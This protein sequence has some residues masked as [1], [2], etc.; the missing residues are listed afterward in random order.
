MLLHT[1]E[2]KNYRSLEHVTLENLTSFNI[3]I[4][5]NDVGK[6]SVFL[7]LEDLNKVLRGTTVS[8]D[9]L[10]ARDHKRSWEVVLM[11]ALRDRDR[12][13]FVD[14]LI[15]GGFA[16]EHRTAL[17]SSPFLRYIQFSFK[18]F[19]SNPNLMHLQETKICAEDGKWATI[20]SILELNNAS[21]PRSKYIQLAAVSKAI[22]QRLDGQ[23]KSPLLAQLLNINHGAPIQETNIQYNQVITTSW[24]NDPATQWLYTQL[25]KYFSDAFFFSSFRHSESSLVAQQSDA[26][27]QNGSNLVQV[28]FTLLANQRRTFDKIN[29][30]VHDAIPDLGDLQTSLAGN[31]TKIDFSDSDNDYA[32]PL[33][34][35]GSGVEQ[36]LM[37]AVVLLT[38][39]TRYHTLFFEEPECHL[40]A[41]ARRFLIDQLYHED[42][43]V[44]IATHSSTFINLS[45]PHSLYRVTQDKGRTFIT[46]CDPESL[47]AVLEDIGVRNSDVLLSDAVLFV[48]GPGDKDVF[49]LLSEK[50]EMLLS[51]RNINV[52]P[53]G[54]GRYAERGAPIRSELLADISQKSPVPHLFVIDR[55]ER[56]E[57][58]TS[59]LERRLHGHIHVLRARELENYLLIP[60]AILHAL[61]AK[62]CSDAGILEKLAATHEE[63]IAQLIQNTANDLYGTVLLKRIRMHLGAPRE[64]LLPAQALITLVPQVHHSD[65]ASNISQEIKTY[66]D[67]HIASI[68]IAAIVAKEKQR[69]DEAWQDHAVRLQ[70]APGEEILA[71][72]FT[73]FGSTYRKSKDALLIAKAMKT[74]DISPE[75][76]ELIARVYGLVSR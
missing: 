69:L 47:D 7:A 76:K 31:L 55:D 64:G 44:F 40:H 73:L 46:K 71:K 33:T 38:P 20:Q 3:L 4:G 62:H 61:N 32:I 16:S 49:T 48:E 12:S 1:V 70:L 60:H 11:F 75:L 56:R 59:A 24:A 23:E 2:I 51:S 45:K 42:R 19:A 25:S 72:I 63:Q 37:V 74:T 26:L 52:L 6:S 53:M 41:G 58:E 10:T 8:S 29:Q 15:A 39:R 22:S 68:D 36:L 54:G 18:S 9:I 50:L 14:L 34:D 13:A 67:N 65:F 43:Q 21:N 57:E 5:R 28:L 17:L 27:A 66:I 35:K 30:F